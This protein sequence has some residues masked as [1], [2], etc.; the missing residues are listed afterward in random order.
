[1]RRIHVHVDNR[2]RIPAGDLG[3]DLVQS[4]KGRFTHVNPTRETLKRIKKPY[5]HLPRTIQTWG[6]ET[7]KGGQELLTLPRGGM[8]RLR[9]ALT[10][11]GHPRTVTDGRVGGDPGGRELPDHLLTLYGYQEQAVRRAIQIEGGIIRAPTGAGKTSIGFALAARL[12]V[13]TLVVVYN[14]GLFDQWV[15]RA[16]KE[17]G[18]PLSQVGII[19]SGERK[20]RPL[21]IAMQQSLRGNVDRELREYFGAVI[22]DE[23]HAA[24]ADTVFQVVDQFPARYRIGI[25]ADHRRKDKKEFLTEDLFGGLI[26]DIPREDLIES[27]HVLDVQIRVIPTDF[28]ADWY[29]M[30]T[31]DQQTREVDTVRLY[32]ELTND[33]PRNELALW[34][35]AEEA[36][37]EQVLVL[38]P[39]R[40]HCRVLDQRIVGMGIRT[41]FLIGGEDFRVEFRKTVKGLESGDIRVGVGTIQAVGQGLDL[42]TVAVGVVA[43][44][45]GSNRQVFNQVRGRF[46]RTSSGKDGARLYY[47]W[48]RHVFGK[49][50]LQNLLQW[51]A[52][53]LVLQDGVW[54]PGKD[55]I[56]GI[57]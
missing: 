11:Y 24:A 40:E 37:A 54:V 43:V 50:H 1:M 9:D 55:F 56:H 27:G 45:L 33:A 49:K 5:H 36:P 10:S 26:D 18:I 48:D 17:L 13:A 29:G 21:T 53:V 23:V 7:Q 35:V 20:L 52:D 51:N 41:G 14:G 3:E 39:R 57:A 42:P 4:L 44:P 31:E 32:E 2:I 8:G 22:V 12:K 28:R 16:T 25:S 30:A 38:S 19:R 6:V 34:A 46:C 47:L 15:K